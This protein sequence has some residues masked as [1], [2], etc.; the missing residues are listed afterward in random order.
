M[1]ETGERGEAAAPP[2]A[3][4]P[5]AGVRPSAAESHPIFTN[6]VGFTHVINEIAARN[7]IVRQALARRAG[8]RAG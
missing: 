6:P 1:H 3:P 5:A 8:G 4:P 2:T 7:P